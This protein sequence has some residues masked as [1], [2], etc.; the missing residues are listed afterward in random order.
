MCEGIKSQIPDSATAEAF[1]KFFT[2]KVE[3]VRFATENAAPPSF[4]PCPK[5]CCIDTFQPL[6]LEQVLFLIKRALHYMTLSLFHTPF[7]PEVASG[8]S[9]KSCTT[10]SICQ[11]KQMSFQLHFESTCISKFLKS[12]R[13]ASLAELEL[14][15][16]KF[17]S[18]SVRRS[19]SS[20]AGQISG[21][22]YNVRQVGRSTANMH[23]M[24]KYAQFER[25]AKLNWEPVQTPKR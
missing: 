1:S 25:Y 4:S 5:P 18:E 2:H 19:E 13:E 16:W 6:T 23:Q 11:Y 24:H 17:I 9:T 7:T 3:S 10:V 12:I 20:S 15:Y 21:R 22:R 14:Q 8:A